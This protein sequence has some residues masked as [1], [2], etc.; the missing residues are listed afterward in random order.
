MIEKER[1]HFQKGKMAG[2]KLGERGMRE[3]KYQI[4]QKY[5]IRM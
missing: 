5:F 3:L 1:S 2:S 4:S